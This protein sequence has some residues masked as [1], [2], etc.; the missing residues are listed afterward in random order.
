M[1]GGRRSADEA[2]R[3]A[4]PIVWYAEMR[5][6]QKCIL[7]TA[8]FPP[9][10]PLCHHRHHHH[11]Y[12]TTTLRPSRP[13][14]VSDE[15]GWLDAQGLGWGERGG[16]GSGGGGGV[17]GGSRMKWDNWVWDRIGW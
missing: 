4:V 14:V 15:G 13:A 10:P 17:S 5:R 3:G 2:E 12:Q 11:Q 7:T 6:W 16:R 9:P 8:Y 1:A